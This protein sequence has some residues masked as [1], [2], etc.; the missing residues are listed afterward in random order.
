M[1]THGVVTTAFAAFV[2]I[3]TAHA[4]TLSE[5][6]IDEG[7]VIADARAAKDAAEKSFEKEATEKKATRSPYVSESEKREQAEAETHSKFIAALD[8]VRGK[9]FW[10]QPNPRVSSKIGFIEPD[11]GVIPKLFEQKKFFVTTETSFVVVGYEPSRDERYRDRYY[12]KLEFP[13][14][15]IGYLKVDDVA[16]TYPDKY[17]V[18]KD[19]YPGKE[20]VSVDFFEYI[21]PRPPQEIFAAENKATAERKS[22]QVKASTERA[23]RGGVTIGMTTAQVLK[24]NWGK[25]NNVNRT[26]TANGAH[27]QWVY[28]DHNFLYFENGILTAIQN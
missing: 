17:P 24:S 23:A 25:P 20:M 3:S 10:Y 27:E 21:Y 18:I 9:I 19:L 5:L 4:A 13:D 7:L 22:K 1:S 2:F 6:P 11:N 26:L 28:H 15:K 12:L 8:A 16:S 14:G